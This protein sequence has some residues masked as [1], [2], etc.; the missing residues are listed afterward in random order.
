M[1]INTGNSINSNE[2]YIQEMK[3]ALQDLDNDLTQMRLESLLD[4]NGLQ[5]YNLLQSNECC[6]SNDLPTSLMV[7]IGQYCDG[8]VL[9]CQI[10]K[11]EEY[12]QTLR[13]KKLKKCIKY[14]HILKQWK[15][16]KCI[17]NEKEKECQHCY[18]D[19]KK[20]YLYSFHGYLYC[21]SCYDDI[22]CDYVGDL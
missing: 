14:D 12:F 8:Y 16:L 11:L 20:K 17:E 5:I 19:F 18:R 15:H 9:Q 1:D 6:L 21:M 2:N 7:L 3:Q 13:S 10:C 4:T 22:R